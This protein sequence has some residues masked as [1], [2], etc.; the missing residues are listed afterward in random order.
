VKA[1]A[2]RAKKAAA[3]VPA[4]KVAADVVPAVVEA[5]A[6]ESAPKVVEPAVDVEAV[7]AAV[8]VPV[9]DTADVVRYVAARRFHHDGRDYWPGDAVPGAEN[10]PRLESRLRQRWLVEA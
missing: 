8:V 2:P 6:V 4:R 1:R 5:V 10:W 7:P 3:K 9:A